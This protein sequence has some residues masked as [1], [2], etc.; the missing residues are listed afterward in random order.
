MTRGPP[1]F[2]TAAQTP[3]TAPCCRRTLDPDR[4]LK[5]FPTLDILASA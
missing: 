5:G 4:A 1:W 2:L 3:N